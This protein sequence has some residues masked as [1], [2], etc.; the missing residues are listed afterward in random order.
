M[1]RALPLILSSIVSGLR[2]LRA[3]RAGGSEAAAR[4]ERDLPMYVVLFGSLGL[5]VVLMLRSRA[6]PGLQRSRAARRAHDPGVRL[7]VRHGVVA[8]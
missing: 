7:S 5:V 6:G 1:L 3:T 2:D 8:A 4:T